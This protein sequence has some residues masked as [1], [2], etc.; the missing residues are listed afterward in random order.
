MVIIMNRVNL[1]IFMDKAG[2]YPFLSNIV[3]RRGN[4][5]KH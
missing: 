2:F 1:I 5:E 3:D 4:I